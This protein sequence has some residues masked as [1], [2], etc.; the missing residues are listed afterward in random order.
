M[1]KEESILQI[2]NLLHQKLNQLLLV[3]LHSVQYKSSTVL[4]LVKV[5]LKMLETVLPVTLIELTH[6]LVTVSMVSMKNTI[7]AKNVY[8]NVLPVKVEVIVLIV[9]LIELI[10]QSVI[11]TLDSMMIK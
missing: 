6:Q 9:L 10:H 4:N 8:S 5:V 1:P 2:V 3:K 7:I 11:V